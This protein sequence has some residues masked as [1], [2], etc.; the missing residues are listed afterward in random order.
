MTSN[1]PPDDRAQ[2]V[3]TDW[4]ALINQLPGFVMVTSGPDHFVQFANTEI[5]EFT[6]YRGVVG[7]RLGEALP[8]LAE[9]GFLGIR[10]EVYRTGRPFRGQAM[11]I[12]LRR[13]PD[14]PF[15]DGY[16]DFVYQ[17]IRR[18]DGSVTG[19]I[20]AGYDVTDRKVAE[21]RMR[22]LQF[23]LVQIFRAS[24]MGAMAM[25]LAH[26]INQPLAA[27][28]NYAAAARRQFGKTDVVKSEDAL[29][30][31]K[32]IEAASHR[33]AEIIRL[34]R[35]MMGKGRPGPE[36]V[37]LVIAIQQAAALGLIDAERKGVTYRLDLA[38]DLVVTG[39]HIQVQ[40]ILLNLMRNAVEAMQACDVRELE[41]VSTRQGKE[42]EIRIAD[43]GP[44]LAEEI[45]DRLFEPFVSTKEQGLG[46]GLSI[47]RALAERHGGRIWAADRAGGGTEF[48]VRL[49][50]SS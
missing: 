49:P 29:K 4:V 5:E 36:P 31:L 45:R 23:E 43:T 50:L 7:H 32:D 42:A 14:G 12:K 30:A 10:D 27:I 34:V 2:I 8:E 40:Q 35:E 13:K 48:V 22:S 37:N 16:I 39:D 24:A 33:A 20:F 3:E 28:S 19:I 9:Q 25:I 11:P 6:H 26:E 44:G 18:E 1:R 41:I 38:P 47:S 17:P 21:D 15:E 46:V